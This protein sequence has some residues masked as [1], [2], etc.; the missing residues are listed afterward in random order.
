[1]DSDSIKIYQLRKL[2]KQSDGTIADLLITESTS[3]IAIRKYLK[4]HRKLDVEN[5]KHKYFI[6]SVDWTRTG[7]R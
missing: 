7:Y 5:G 3:R 2:E 6:K 4:M 1:M